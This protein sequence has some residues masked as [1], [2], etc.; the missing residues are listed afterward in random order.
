MITINASSTGENNYILMSNNNIYLKI[1]MKGN[2]P[3]A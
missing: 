3:I 2:R 1:T